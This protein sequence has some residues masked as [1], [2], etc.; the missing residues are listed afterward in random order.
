MTTRAFPVRAHPRKGTR[1]VRQHARWVVPA[2]F[3]PFVQKVPR[4][5]ALSMTSEGIDGLK[6]RPVGE[7]MEHL[8]AGDLYDRMSVNRVE[9]RLRKGLPLDP[10]QILSNE[11][12]RQVILLDGHHRVLAA[13]RAKVPY[14]YVMESTPE[15]EDL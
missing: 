10:V 13:Q 3:R 2:K 12:G 9:Q 6:Y 14:I 5:T 15:T 1:G 4:E 8:M 11:G 7:S